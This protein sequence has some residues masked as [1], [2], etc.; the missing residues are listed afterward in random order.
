MTKHVTF[1]ELSV[2]DN[3]VPL[4]SG[5]LQAY[6][7]Q[8]PVIAASVDFRFY[9]RSLRQDPEQILA[10]L[11]DLDSDVYAFS[12]YIWN[13]GLIRRLLAGLL[14]ERPD[15]WFLLGGAQV[16]NH[17]ADYIPAGA[18]NVVVCNG[19]GE[20]PCYEFL[21]QMLVDEPDLA[22]VSGVT[23]RT[24]HGE[25]V[26]TDKPPR[27][28]TLDD[29]PSPFAAGLFDGQDYTFTV[30]ETNRGCPFHCGFCFWG[31]ATNSKV[32][33]FD[34]DRV[35]GDIRWIA[36]HGVASVFIADANWGLSPR[37]VELSK[38]IVSCQEEF[39]F[40]TSM[41][42]AAAKN[43]P[44]RVAEITEILVRG[45]LVTSQPISLQTVNTDTLRLI[46]RENIRE[47]TYTELQRSLNEKRISSFIEM[48][49]P[50]PGE[51]LE[52][53][54][55]GIARLCRL[56]ADTLTVYPQLLLH[57]TALYEQRETMGIEV[58]RAPDPVAEADVVV[59]TRWVD[60]AECE[61]GTWFYYLVQSLYN[62][63]G[64]YHL[65]GY[66][67]RS[68]LQ[69]Y[70]DFFTA[71]TSFWQ[72]ADNE[73]C[74]FVADSVATAD[75]YDL[76]NIGKAAHLVLHSHRH[77][78]DALLLDF[79]RSQ[80]WWSDAGARCAT[81][82]DLVARPYIYREPVQAP[83]V[84]LT[85]ARL[86]EVEDTRIVVSLPEALAQLPVDLRLV[87]EPTTGLCFEHPRDGKMPVPRHH[88]IEQNASY[89]H[90][91]IQRLR[92]LLPTCQPMG[93]STL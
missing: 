26:T 63:R 13:T 53:F 38:H 19:E 21:R 55:A 31:A 10:E 34:E 8:D 27:L 6:A 85:E 15:A 67:D 77:A 28:R 70:E 82:L 54:K 59:A 5:Y 23:F 45:G 74:R 57:N 79:A 46:D 58:E 66:L 32:Y 33:K 52:T 62:A 43:R 48:I 64:A 93:L 68:G 49:W 51:T 80:P 24:G 35:R 17:G 36:E 30:L 92:T 25:L 88:T 89:C 18:N 37:D 11:L 44:E 81:D 91:M 40:P 3:T 65:A 50:L 61:Q 20:Q 75:N 22:E 1:V 9:S 76:L 2:Y 86:L 47:A 29:V 14:A 72:R 71:A 69:S 78:F 83:G 87:S 7:M 16:M 41:V 73:L 39:G 42:L 60:R 4:V 12:C 84:E 90:V 56:E